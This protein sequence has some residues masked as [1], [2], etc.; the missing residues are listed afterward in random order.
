MLLEYTCAAR[1]MCSAQP[2]RTGEAV[3]TRVTLQ[4]VDGLLVVALPEELTDRLQLREGDELC[5]LELERGVTLTT[6]DPEFDRA[7][8]AYERVSS[9]YENALRQLAQ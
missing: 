2:T 8:E 1:A 6:H 5:V 3:M 4:K 7:M 9:R